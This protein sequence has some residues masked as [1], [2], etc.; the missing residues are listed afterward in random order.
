MLISHSLCFGFFAASCLPPPAVYS[1]FCLPT[2]LRLPAQLCC[3]ASHHL[4]ESPSINHHSWPFSLYCYVDPNYQCHLGRVSEISHTFSILFTLFCFL[5]INQSL[6]RWF[7]S[8]KDHLLKSNMAACVHG[9]KIP[10]G[11]WRCCKKPKCRNTLTGGRADR[12]KASL[13]PSQAQVPQGPNLPQL[14][15]ESH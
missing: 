12:A 14:T 9:E 7:I 11:K 13:N 3:S 15:R 5:S 1:K 4:K 10:D 2:L 8:S 6:H